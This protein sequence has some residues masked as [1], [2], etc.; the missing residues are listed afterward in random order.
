M[1]QIRYEIVD[2]RLYKCV[3]TPLDEDDAPKVK[4]GR[5]PRTEEPKT[6]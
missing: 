1:E 6:E 4:R 3:I 2:G 5:P